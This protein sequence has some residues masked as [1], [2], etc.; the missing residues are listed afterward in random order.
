MKVLVGGVVRYVVRAWI[1]YQ[2]RFFGGGTETTAAPARPLLSGA[3]FRQQFA[4]E[5]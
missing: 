4:S 2:K 3:S 1:V 5:S